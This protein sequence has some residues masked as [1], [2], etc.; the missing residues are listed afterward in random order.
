MPPRSTPPPKSSFFPPYDNATYRDLLLFEERL[1]ITAASLQKRKKKYQLFLFQLLAIIAFLLYEVLAPPQ[2]SILAIPYTLLL[3]KVLPEIYGPGTGYGLGY[4]SS[5]MS[6]DDDNGAARELVPVHPFLTTGLLFVS[7]TTLVLFFAS[8]MYSEKIGYANKYVP[9]ANKALRS[10]NMYLNVRK[11]PLRSKFYWNPMSFFFPRPEEPSHSHARTGSRSR[12]STPSPSQQRPSRSSTPRS[13]RSPSPTPPSPSSNSFHDT[14]ST[15]PHPYSQRR[16]SSSSSSHET[17]P[18][19]PYPYP[20]RR[21][22]TPSKSLSSFPTQTPLPISPIPP[23]KYPR[24]ELII[25]SKVDKSFRES[26]ERYRAAFERRRE[27]REREEKRKKMKAKVW[28]VVFFWRKQDEEESNHTHTRT[29]SITSTS[30]I[31]YD[32][33]RGMRLGTIS[34][35]GTPPGS[36]GLGPGGRQRSRSRQRSGT[37]PLSPGLVPS[38]P[39]SPSASGSGSGSASVS[40]SPGSPGRRRS[41]RLKTQSQRAS[42]R[43]VRERMELNGL[44]RDGD[45]DR[46]RERGRERDMNVDRDVDMRTLA[47]ERSLGLSSS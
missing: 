31:G 7:V 44:G 5:W 40:S 35:G 30:S 37:P 46:G 21:S 42:L 12:P 39:S 36:A 8:G 25:S 26:Y 17:Q 9:H 16:S 14:Q 27:E 1:K 41:D 2:S 13:S 19:H 18:I 15:H 29:V 33:Q 4:W 28:R 6:S 45:G 38:P 3:Q 43:E 20:Q 32:T 34:R 23:A 22:T 11:P 24:G 10:F 47:L